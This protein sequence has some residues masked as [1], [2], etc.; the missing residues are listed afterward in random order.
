MTPEEFIA[1]FGSVITVCLNWQSFLAERW[2]VSV[3]DLRDRSDLNKF[4]VPWYLDGPGQFIQNAT[5][6]NPPLQ[7]CTIP[8]RLATLPNLQKT[9]IERYAQQFRQATDPISFRIPAYTL[10]RGRFFALDC[11]HRLSA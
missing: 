8:G 2:P 6:S 3:R 1:E 4:F 10:P 7:V 9:G 5:P 11:N